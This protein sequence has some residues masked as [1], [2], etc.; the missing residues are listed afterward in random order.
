MKLSIIIPIY[1]AE[2]Y[3]DR[4]LESLWKQDLSVDEY[5]VICINDGSTDASVSILNKCKEKHTNLKLIST[6]N[7]GQAHARNKGLEIAKGEYITFVDAD[8]Y[9]VIDSLRKVLDYIDRNSLDILYANILWQD[10]DGIIYEDNNIIG[11]DNVISDGLIHQRRTLPPTFYKRE[12]IGKMIFPTKV[13]IG[14]DTIFNALVQLKAKKV[15]FFSEPYYVYVNTPNSLSKKIFTDK[16]YIGFLEALKQLISFKEHEI[17]ST[18]VLEKK[19]IDSVILIFLN[20]IIDFHILPNF[21]DKKYLSLM[22]EIKKDNKH[23]LNEI[24]TKY[25]YF[26]NNFF[27]FKYYQKW[28]KLKSK[29]YNFLFK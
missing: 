22:N 15:S 26:G 29:I 5:E 27:S 14:E 8:D 16:A 25:P 12:L 21:D 20:R 13:M 4:C 1:N 9:I 24:N 10:N 11:K 17:Y 23:L 19:Y 18:S 7:K 3:L 28:L 2:K 6:E